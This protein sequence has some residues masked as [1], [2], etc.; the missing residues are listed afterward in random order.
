MSSKLQPFFSDVVLQNHYTC[1]H[2]RN[3]IENNVTAWQQAAHRAYA[4][5][6]AF[7]LHDTKFVHNFYLPSQCKQMD[8][9]YGKQYKHASWFQS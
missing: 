9:R 2:R 5:V 7:W 1:M 3:G 8:P 4:E 6:S